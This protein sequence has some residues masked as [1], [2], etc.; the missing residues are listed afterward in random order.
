MIRTFHPVG[1]GAF[2]TE[3][4]DN[5]NV[6]YDCGNWRNTRL[7]GQVV[8]NSFEPGAEIHLLFISH[9]D[10]DHVSKLNV[11]RDNF[12]IHKVVLPLLHYDEKL[13]IKSFYS[14]YPNIEYRNLCRLV[15]EPSKFFNEASITT[16]DVTESEES[17]NTNDSINYDNLGNRIKSG[18]L[19]RI[20]N[21]IYVPFNIYYRTRNQELLDLLKVNNL[22]VFQMRNDL[23]Y[24]ID[25]RRKIKEVYDKVSGNINQNSMLVYSGPLEETILHV[26]NQPEY[27]WWYNQCVKHEAGCIYTGDA[28]LNLSNIYN[29]YRPFWNKVGTIQV[30]HH[31]SLHN[32]NEHV[33]ND[34][35]KCRCYPISHGKANSY[36]HPSNAVLINIAKNNSCG[37][38]V[39]EDLD[40]AFIQIID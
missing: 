19:I 34:M 33:F 26:F 24:L 4:H 21:W 25:N 12:K 28:D 14:I 13:L 3:R 38:S 1:Q 30:P 6:V 15:D 32:F 39:T 31:G 5:F 11:L 2:Y 22:D 18:Q 16:V 7:S 23:T 20:L 8:K 40:S 10:Y 35:G 37:K 29:I 17:A 36:G 9:F 27:H